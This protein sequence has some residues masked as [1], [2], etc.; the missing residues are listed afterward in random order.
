MNQRSLIAIIILAGIS[1]IGSVLAYSGSISAAQ[2]NFNNVLVTGSCTGCGAEGTFTTFSVLTNTTLA[3][4]QISTVRTLQV[5][6]NGTIL[7]DIRGFDNILVDVTGNI[8]EEQTSN[9]G[10]TP[11]GVY[12]IAQSTSGKYKV[13]FDESGTND[14]KIFKNDSFLESH[15]INPAY[16]DNPGCSVAVSNNGKYIAL[17][18]DNFAGTA[19]AMTIFQGS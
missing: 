8:I 19:T 16:Y 17:L 15:H 10:T 3:T 2:G 7:A 11:T 6:D 18:C 9:S 4:S 5:S 12:H 1:S 14:L 13:M